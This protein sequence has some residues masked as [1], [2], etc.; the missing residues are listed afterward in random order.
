MTV[1]S[2]DRVVLPGGPAGPGWVRLDG[3]AGGRIADT[4]SGAPP[5]P[6]DRHAAVLVPGFVDLHVHGGGGH[7]ASRSPADLAGAVAFHRRH[8]TTATLVSLVTAPV[9]RLCEQLGWIAELAADPDSGVLGAH[10]EGPFLSAARCGAQNP[11]HLLDP[12]PDVWR[13]LL[14]A[15]RG[16]LRTITVAPELPGALELVDAAL[17]AGVVVAVGHTDAAYEQARAAFDRGATL[18]THLYNGMRSVHHREPGP[19]VAALEAGVACELI[20]DGVHVHPAMLRLLDRD[21][22]PVLITD[23]IDAA[24]AGDGDYR[25]GGQ[26]VRVRDGVA[27]L[28]AGGDGGS[29]AG[30]TLTMDAA[31]RRAVD[32]RISLERAVAAASTTPAAVLGLGSSHGALAP[33]RRAD[34]VLLDAGLRAEAVFVAGTEMIGT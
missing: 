14:E 6:A 24:G 33:G 11:A 19:V 29:I 7:D 31:V 21:G 26:A 13:A 25:L 12:D 27:R 18:A 5:Q 9:E 8:G 23:A 1:L 22:H 4:G 20:N 34:L 15:G 32:N 16:H 10:L 30:S 17:A 3:A 2:A 28:A